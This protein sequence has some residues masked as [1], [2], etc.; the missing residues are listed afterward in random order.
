VSTKFWD[1]Q[2]LKNE[3]L[4]YIGDAK[5]TCK[6][7]GEVVFALIPTANQELNELE[8]NFVRYQQKQKNL[9]FE[10]TEY[11]SH[12]LDRKLKIEAM[13]DVMNME[14]E[15]IQKKLETFIGKV[16]EVDNSK[17]LAYGLIA[18]IKQIGGK[19]HTIDGQNVS[20]IDDVNCIDDPRSPYDGLSLFDYRKLCSAFYQE[21]K[22]KQ[23]EQLIKVQAECRERGLPVV[24]H[25]GATTFKRVSKSSLPPFPADCI[26]HKTKKPEEESSSKSLTRTK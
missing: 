3:L 26:N 25:V 14:V 7:N 13:L 11:P 2:N 20:M 12:V 15:F 1:E 10:I 4:H 6:K 9:G 8:A 17:V 18:S 22:R 21:Q 24:S 23:K 5:G 19:V 16:E